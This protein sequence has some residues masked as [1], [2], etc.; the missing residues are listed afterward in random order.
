MKTREMINFLPLTNDLVTIKFFLTNHINNHIIK[1]DQ[2]FVFFIW[3][4]VINI[5]INIQII[6]VFSKSFRIITMLQ[7]YT[8]AFVN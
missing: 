5:S 1:Y 6:Q 8:F 2:Y 4:V 7:A 3:I